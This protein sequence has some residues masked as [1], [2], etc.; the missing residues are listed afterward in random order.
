MTRQEPSSAEHT[1]QPT[2]TSGVPVCGELLLTE[3]RLA[4][5]APKLRALLEDFRRLEG[6]ESPDVEPA[7]GTVATVEANADDR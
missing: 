6:L 4:L 5:L 7:F 1:A 3:A 2:T